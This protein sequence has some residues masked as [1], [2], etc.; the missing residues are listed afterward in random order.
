MNTIYRQVSLKVGCNTSLVLKFFM[1]TR[2]RRI[3]KKARDCFGYCTDGGFPGSSAGK[4]STCSAGDSGSVPVLGRSSGG[5]HGTPLQ[6]SCLEN[7]MDRGA[8]WATVHGVTKSNMT[9]STWHAL[10][11]CLLIFKH[12]KSVCVSGGDF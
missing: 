4:E 1:S 8:W 10:Y 11:R 9:E 2:N 6:Y 3:C 12:Q 5:R 7:P